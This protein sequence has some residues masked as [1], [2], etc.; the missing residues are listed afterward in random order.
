MAELGETSDAEHRAVGALARDLGIEVVA[1]AAPAYGGVP[2]AGLDE[3][4]AALGPLGEGDAVLL[5]A[6]RVVGLERLVP[7]LR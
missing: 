1:V 3:A 2:V 6:S 5:K 4:L 7:R